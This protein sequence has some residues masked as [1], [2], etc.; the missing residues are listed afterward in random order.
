MIKDLISTTPDL[1]LPV[2][3]QDDIVLSVEGVSKRFCRDLKRSLF[4]GLKDIA[5]EITGVS[6]NKETLRKGEF[7]ALHDINFSLRKG[8]AVGLIGANGAG[9]TTVLKII[10]G[11]IK[12]DA[13]QVKIKGRL[14]PL[15]GLGA[16]FNHILTGRENMYV[17]MSIL[18]LTYEQITDRFEEVVAFSEI[19]DAIDAP[20][21]TYSSGMAARLGFACAIHTDP[22]IL[23]IDEVLA[24]GDIKFRMKCYRKLAQL[25]ANGTSFIL[26]SHSSQ[27]LLS[28]CESGI[29][30]KKGKLLSS[31][32]IN[33]VIDQYEQELFGNPSL[34]D[35]LPGKLILP[36]KT[37]SESFGIDFL[38]IC[39]KDENGN[40]LDSLIA[41]QSAILNIVLEAHSFFDDIGIQ[42][43]IRELSA[44]NSNSILIDSRADGEKLS[45]TPT[46]FE[47]NINLPVCCWRQ[48]RYTAKF[49]VNRNN[50]VVDMLD[51]V[52]S[53]TF[54]VRTDDKSMTVSSFYQ[55]RTWEINHSYLPNLKINQNIK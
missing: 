41:G 17:N 31:G 43:L 48:G 29:Y 26:V 40:I 54:L 3:N 15:I 13:G 52:E 24:V 35:R 27:S 49:N 42:V 2:S 9:K 14:A 25:R 6:K 8:E 1:S 33:K 19:G 46:V 45:A 55:P 23:L 32:D 28:V 12:P 37:K 5:S 34:E 30:F 47:L 22:D 44:E 21:K 7:W 11:L 20:V 50:N 10:S 36:K 38:E 16:G 4:Y 39:F 51:A 18:G 53:F